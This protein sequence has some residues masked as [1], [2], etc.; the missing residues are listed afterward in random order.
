MLDR[1]ERDEIFEIL[2]SFKDDKFK[3]KERVNDIETHI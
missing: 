3:I 2:K 1:D